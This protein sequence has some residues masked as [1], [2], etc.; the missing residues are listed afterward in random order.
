MI[1]PA[2]G[3]T[4]STPAPVDCTRCLELRHYVELAVRY[5]DRK[6]AALERS[7]LEEHI[8]ADHWRG[9]QR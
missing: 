4:P 2:T 5:G 9:G 6:F 1:K 3:P 7:K 8:L